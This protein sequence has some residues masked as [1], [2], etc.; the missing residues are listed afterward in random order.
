MRTLGWCGDNG[1]NSN[2]DTFTLTLL[3]VFQLVI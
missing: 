1:G 3:C 2:D